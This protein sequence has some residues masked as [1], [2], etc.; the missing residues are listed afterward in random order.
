MTALNMDLFYHDYRPIMVRMAIRP[1][2]ALNMDL[3]YHDYRPI[4]VRMAIRPLNALNM[5][6]F[7]H[8][9]R[10]EVNHDT[11]GHSA[12]DCHE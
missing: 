3:F 6:L 4:M 1:L 12:D 11:D 7:Y 8:D 10:L 5:D 9:H 2:N